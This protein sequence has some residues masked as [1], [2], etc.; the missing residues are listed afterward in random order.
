MKRLLNGTTFHTDSY[1]VP[2]STKQLILGLYV[3]TV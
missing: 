1:W 3:W 2:D